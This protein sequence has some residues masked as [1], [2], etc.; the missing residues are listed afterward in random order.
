VDAVQQAQGLAVVALSHGDMSAVQVDD[1]HAADFAARN[2]VAAAASVMVEG[3]IEVAFQIV[4]VAEVDLQRAEPGRADGRDGFGGLQSCLVKPQRFVVG[5]EQMLDDGEVD[6]EHQAFIQHTGGGEDRPRGGR[7]GLSLGHALQV[8]AD[9]QAA[10]AGSGPAN[11]VVDSAKALAGF[12]EGGPGLGGATQKLQRVAASH[13][14]QGDM[15]RLVAHRA[16]GYDLFGQLQRAVGIDH[17]VA[18]GLGLALGHQRGCLV[19]REGGQVVGRRR[20]LSLGAWHRFAAFQPSRAARTPR[21][22]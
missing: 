9:Q 12:A 16:D 17:P 15:L 6:V 2:A 19:G 4:Q 3:A 11:L 22:A 13:Q 14:A 5:A 21:H 7:V 18:V 8:H 10:D 20:C 1:R